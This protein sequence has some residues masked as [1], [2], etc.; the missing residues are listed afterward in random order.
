MLAPCTKLRCLAFS[1]VLAT[2]SA[3][4]FLTYIHFSMT[5]AARRAAK[6]PYPN[7]YA[8]AEDATKDPAKFAFN[9]SQRAHSN[10]LEQLPV[11]FVSM[12]VGGLKYPV[13]MSAMGSV[14]LVGR[15]LYAWGYRTSKHNST[16]QGRYKG[17]ISTIVQAPMAAM[18]LYAG[19]Q[20]AMG[21]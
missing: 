7:C 6:V 13:A 10:F 2:V 3:S 21:L 11:F 5:G 9:C 15:V 17:I 1:Y 19:Y 20:F 18:T 4:V 16:G 12:L 14:W 8:T